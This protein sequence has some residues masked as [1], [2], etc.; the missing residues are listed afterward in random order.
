MFHDFF[1]FLMQ[2]HSAAQVA[3]NSLR[4]CQQ[5]L[6]QLWNALYNSLSDEVVSCLNQSRQRVQHLMFSRDRLSQTKMNV[7]L[8]CDA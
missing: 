2:G 8:L 5:M 4:I 3:K 7:L 1:R 6:P